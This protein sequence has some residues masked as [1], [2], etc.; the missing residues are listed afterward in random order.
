[1]LGQIFEVTMNI[2]ANGTRHRMSKRHELINDNL[3]A[4]LQ[5]YTALDVIEKENVQV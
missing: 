4:Y 3:I 5:S 1:M 2:R